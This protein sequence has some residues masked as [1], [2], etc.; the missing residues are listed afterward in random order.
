MHNAFQITE[1]GLQARNLVLVKHTAHTLYGI[2]AGC[3]PHDQLAYHRVVKD[4]NLVPFVHV[5]V[6]AYADAVRLRQLFD[7]KIG[8]AS[9]R[10]RV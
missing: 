8:R 2:L 6:N 3:G 7:D 1:V 4:R 10:E 5:A 9:C